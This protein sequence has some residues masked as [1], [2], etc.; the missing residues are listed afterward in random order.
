MK[1]VVKNLAVTAVFASVSGAVIYKVMKDRKEKQED[2]SIKNDEDTK[3]K[4]NLSSWDKET[5]AS[6]H[7]KKLKIG[8]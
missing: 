2:R 3:G 4:D 8:K 5:C 7:Y 1:K 6:R